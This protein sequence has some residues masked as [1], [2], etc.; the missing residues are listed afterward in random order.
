MITPACRVFVVYLG[1]A[2]TA[3][4][5]GGGGVGG[6]GAGTGLGASTPV[7]FPPQYHSRH[8]HYAQHLERKIVTRRVGKA[9][10]H[11]VRPAG[12]AED[13]TPRHDA[14][15]ETSITPIP[16]N[17]THT[18]SVGTPLFGLDPRSPGT[19]ALYSQMLPFIFS[20]APR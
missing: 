19:W 18:L 16:I 17:K 2:G 4:A 3:V 10:R 7:T 8:H 5:H 14:S 15:S 13:L 9:E 20:E 1:L 12:Y 11:H 6:A